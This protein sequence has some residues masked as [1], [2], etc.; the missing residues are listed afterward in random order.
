M[1]VAKTKNN[2]FAF[3]IMP[4]NEN[5]KDIYQLGIKDACKEVGVVAERV[6]EQLFEE[7]MLERIYNQIEVA[8]I[9]IAELTQHNANVFYELGLAHAKDKLCLLVTKDAST[10]P[11][12]LKQKRHIIYKSISELKA[13][14]ISNLKWA[15]SELQKKKTKKLEISPLVK[16]LNS[17][18]SKQDVNLLPRFR[19]ELAKNVIDDA[20]DEINAIISGPYDLDIGRERNFLVR[21]APLFRN[22]NKINA[23]SLS[24]VSQFWIDSEN[25]DMAMTYLRS[26]PKSTNRLFVFPTA[27]EANEFKNVL[28]ENYRQ[29]GKEGGVYMCSLAAYEDFLNSFLASINEINSRLEKDFGLLT[30]EHDGNE[31]FVEAELDSTKLCFKPIEKPS[32]DKIIHVQVANLFNNLSHLNPGVIHP[33]YKIAKW[34]PEYKENHFDWALMLKNLFGDRSRSIYHFVFFKELS[35]DINSVIKEL[36][37]DLDIVQKKLAR[38]CDIEVLWFGLNIN[39]PMKDGRFFGKLEIS[40]EYKYVLVMRFPSHDDL[41]VYYKDIKHSESREKLHSKLDS[42]VR[43]LYSLLK[44]LNCKDASSL[45]NCERL[46]AAIESIAAKH[47]VRMDYKDD[48]NIEEIASKDGVF[49][50]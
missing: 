27:D 49:F 33:K 46:F 37:R 5:Y 9:V 31:V 12:D 26:Q 18:V 42:N 23:I 24:W 10:I 40:Q 25:A 17:T 36:K 29:Y 43:Y 15:K 6:D 44:Q 45:K 2:H 7:G 3:V 14:L 1:N 30:Y 13:E 41:E 8:D 21:A 19:Y 38:I 48:E 35:D 20:C 11:F 22:A 50:G 47:I 32:S 16:E 39:L 4:F 34:H 28:N